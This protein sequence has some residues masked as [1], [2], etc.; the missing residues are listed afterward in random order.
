MLPYRTEARQAYQQDGFTT[1]L[2]EVFSTILLNGYL[3]GALYQ[4]APY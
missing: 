4:N 1:Y 3:C 2:K